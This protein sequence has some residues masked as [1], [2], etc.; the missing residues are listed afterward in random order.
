M[1]FTFIR[2]SKMNTTHL[3]LG[4]NLGD[5]ITYLDKA[6]FLI[7]NK[8]GEVVKTSS[9]YETAPW[10]VENQ[11]NY[12]NQVLV[13]QTTLNPNILLK[14]TQEIEYELGRRRDKTWEAR[15][16]DIDILFFNQDVVNQH[17]LVIPHP[18]LHERKFCLEPL[19]EISPEY[20]HP[21]KKHTIKYLL[22]ICED[23][24][25]VKKIK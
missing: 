17:D 3:I 21:I 12:Y 25:L 7:E 6:K 1:F 18:L 24:L 23:S 13:V 4:T 5:R 10:G 8:V 15:E 9:V 19:F 16:I 14:I 20:I 22:Q 2:E 11:Q